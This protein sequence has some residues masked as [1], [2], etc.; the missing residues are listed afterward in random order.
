MA[1]PAV[2]EWRVRRGRPGRGTLWRISVTV[3]A[4]LARHE[5]QATGKYKRRPR[6]PCKREVAS[7]AAGALHWGDSPA[8]AVLSGR[9][10]S[11]TRSPRA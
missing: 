10:E 7:K 1:A 8:S 9:R 4:T 5:S 6:G 2:Y 3:C 11:T